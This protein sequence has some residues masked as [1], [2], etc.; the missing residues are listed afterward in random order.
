MFYPALRLLLFLCGYLCSLEGVLLSLQAKHFSWP[1]GRRHK[2]PQFKVQG[3]G[4]VE[5]GGSANLN[6]ITP[7]SNSVP[8]ISWLTATY[9]VP[10]W[11]VFK[12]GSSSVRMELWT[13]MLSVCVETQKNFDL[14]L[15]MRSNEVLWSYA[16]P[17]SWTCWWEGNQRAD[18]I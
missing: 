5:S 18:L 13:L 2:S 14:I 7:V 9:C 4:C 8:V 3:A 6:L 11:S 10:T 12:N 1:R 16:V 15:F 17:A